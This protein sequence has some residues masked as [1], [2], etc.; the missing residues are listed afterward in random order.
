MTGIIRFGLL[1]LLLI[2]LAEA[3][4]EAY[5]DPGAG[6]LLLQLLL[7]GVAALGV[8]GK[9]F[10]ERLTLPFKRRPDDTEKS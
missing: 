8:V 2:A 6:S 5:L 1:A 9:L 3:P 4:V 10:W 7:G